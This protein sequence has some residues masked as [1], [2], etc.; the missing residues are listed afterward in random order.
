MG[1]QS[2]ASSASSPWQ[3]PRKVMQKCPF[4][5]WQQP[6]KVIQKCPFHPWQQPRK[7]T[8]PLRENTFTLRV[9]YASLESVLGSVLHQ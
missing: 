8:C 5:P 3:Q 6:R 9:A 7:D 4:Q 2:F 1:L